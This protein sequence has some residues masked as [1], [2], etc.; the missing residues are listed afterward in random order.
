MTNEQRIL[1]VQDGAKFMNTDDCFI[2][3]AQ[4]WY[5]VLRAHFDRRQLQ[6]GKIAELVA[7]NYATIK[8]G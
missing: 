4:K 8:H 5:K 1:M 6:L 2:T 3:D 7:K